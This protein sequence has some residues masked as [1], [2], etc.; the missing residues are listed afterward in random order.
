MKG[1]GFFGDPANDGLCSQCFKKKN[2]TIAG[3]PTPAKKPDEAKK[4]K[5]DDKNPGRQ[6]G[7][8]TK[9][10]FTTTSLASASQ[11]VPC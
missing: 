7:L 9:G 11:P 5:A 1:C 4:P 6:V 8:C 10:S 3:P 2:P